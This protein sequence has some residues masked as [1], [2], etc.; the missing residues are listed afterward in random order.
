ML[1]EKITKLRMDAMKAKD[2]VKLS[3]LTTLKGDIDRRR[4]NMNDTVTDEVVPL[5][6]DTPCA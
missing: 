5:T 1:Y 2:K 6:A 3:T 4:I